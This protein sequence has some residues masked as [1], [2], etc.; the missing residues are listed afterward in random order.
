M[1]KITVVYPV[2]DF[3]ELEQSAKDKV[4]ND[5]ITFLLETTTEDEMPDEMRKAIDKA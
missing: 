4:I 5:Q 2:Y 1:K 3:D